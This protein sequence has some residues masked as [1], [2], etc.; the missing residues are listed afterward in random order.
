[1]SLKIVSEDWRRSLYEFGEGQWKIAK[2]VHVKEDSV[3][4]NHFHLEKDECFLLVEGEIIELYLENREESLI[5]NIK[6]PFVINVPRGLYHKFNIK[7]GSKLVG[8]MSE[9]YKPE[10]DHV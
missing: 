6:A 5:K 10:D 4:G 7:A 8:L 2:L 1:M 3:I 9:Q